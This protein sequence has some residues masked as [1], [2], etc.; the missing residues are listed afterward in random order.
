MLEFFVALILYSATTGPGDFH[1]TVTYAPHPVAYAFT[2]ISANLDNPVH[3]SRQ[4]PDAIT[5][6]TAV[7]RIVDIG[8]S[9]CRIDPHFAACYDFLLSRNP[10]NSIMYLL[11]YFRS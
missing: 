9:D 10:D 3:R 8:F 6:Q 11:E 7:S 4:N 5:Q 2:N 1:D